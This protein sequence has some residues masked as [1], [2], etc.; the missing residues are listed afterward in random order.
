MKGDEKMPYIKKEERP[1]LDELLEP[2]IKT[3]EKVPPEEKDGKVCYVIFKLLKRIYRGRFFN[4]NRALGVL[5]SVMQEFYR[6]IVAPHEDEKIK[7]NG[8]VE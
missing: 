2:L 5:N 4:L 7:E 8:D 1:E 3:L 6:R